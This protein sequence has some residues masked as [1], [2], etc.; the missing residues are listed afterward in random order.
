MANKKSVVSMDGKGGWKS[1]VNGNSRPSFTGGTQN[2]VYRKQRDS[3]A[4]N[5][6]GEI[7]VQGRNGR[8]TYKN[9]ISPMKDPYPPKG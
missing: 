1:T 2:E 6:G 3:F 9:T 4:R 5:G 7:T 8:F